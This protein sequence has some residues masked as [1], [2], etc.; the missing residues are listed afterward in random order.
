MKLE[1]VRRERGQ[2]Q[3]LPEIGG[4]F[5]EHR[6]QNKWLEVMQRKEAE[7]KEAVNLRDTLDP[8]CRVQ[9]SEIATVPRRLKLLQEIFA[10]Q[11]EIKQRDP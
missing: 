2:T 5:L 8:L 4:A 1:K 11:G 10:S 6:G 3:L 9:E 7:N